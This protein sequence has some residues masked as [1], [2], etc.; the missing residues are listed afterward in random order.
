MVNTRK[1]GALRFRN[2]K[3]T[4]VEIDPMEGNTTVPEP[5]PL[6]L[7]K[8]KAPLTKR[9]KKSTSTGPRKP[10]AMVPIIE[11]HLTSSDS[12]PKL[13]ELIPKKRKNKTDKKKIGEPV[14]ETPK[15]K[16]QGPKEPQTLELPHSP[17]EDFLPSPE[18]PDQTFITPPQSPTTLEGDLVQETEAEI[19][20]IVEEE[21]TL[22]T[23]EPGKEQANVT[24]KEALVE[25]EH[26]QEH[27]NVPKAEIKNLVRIAMPQ[28]PK[29]K[30]KTTKQRESQPLS[31]NLL[32]LLRR[33]PHPNNLMSLPRRTP[34]PNSLPSHKRKKPQHHSQQRS[35]RR[36][37][38]PSSLL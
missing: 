25:G 12:N 15:A 2:T 36:K 7:V 17:I 28:R 22:R 24:E 35:Q 38:N 21:Q 10:S 6:K 34:H 19:E 37:H 11:E 1:K 30:Q 26:A 5:F 23:E 18:H 9:K 14:E 20:P 31:N 32:S 3:D 4:P 13:A 29:K 27:E 33:K 8:T 16:N